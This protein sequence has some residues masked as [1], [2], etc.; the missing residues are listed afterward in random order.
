SLDK[1]FQHMLE[2]NT[3]HSLYIRGPQSIDLVFAHKITPYL[4]HNNNH[5][6][7]DAF[8]RA[9]NM[10]WFWTPKEIK[11][12]ITLCLHDDYLIIPCDKEDVQHEL[13]LLTSLN[14]L[15]Y[16]EFDASLT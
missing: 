1:E 4:V 15:G 10:T 5:V 8:V 11:P 3:I 16:I 13:N 7:L 12:S 2:D 14:T 6:M 9:W